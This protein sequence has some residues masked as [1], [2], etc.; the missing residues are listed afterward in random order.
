MAGPSPLTFGQMSTLRALQKWPG[1]RWPEG[2]LIHRHRIVDARADVDDVRAALRGV[3][4]HHAALRTTFDLRDV[5]N[6]VHVIHDDVAAGTLVVAGPDEAAD[7]LRTGPLTLFDYDT[8]RGWRAF[9][10]LDAHGRPDELLLCMSH[11]IVDG[12]S[13]RHLDME[14]AP[15]IGERPFDWD[16]ATT[17]L[18]TT[19]ELADLQRGDAWAGRRE[20]AETYW[21]DFFTLAPVHRLQTSG[22]GAEADGVTCGV[23]HL[24]GHREAIATINRRGRVFLG[25]V[26]LAFLGLALMR[27]WDEDVLPMAL[28]TSNRTVPVW[29]DVVTTVN[30]QIPALLHRPDPDAQVI[31][32]IADVPRVSVTAHRNGCYDVDMADRVAGE[33]LGAPPRSFGPLLNFTARGDGEAASPPPADPVVVGGS[34][35]G[36]PTDVYI[37]VNDTGGLSIDLFAVRQALPAPAVEACLRWIAEA[38]T[39]TAQR[40]SLRIRDLPAL[41]V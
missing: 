35:Q 11:L 20:Q 16:H 26:V 32:H 18:R 39:L 19:A 30:Q 25:G 40:E 21:R 2:N 3:A 4:R 13:M 33:L 27:A 1:H 7:V 10:T 5:P 17:S 41:T 31:A 37:A 22:V 24:D 12:W 14:L 6:P 29:R 34:P 38:L 9:L 28:M 15:L 23:L 36:I 8:D